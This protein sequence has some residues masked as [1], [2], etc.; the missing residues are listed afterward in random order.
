[1]SKE[2]EKILK[3]AIET[4]IEMDIKEVKCPE[5]GSDC[6]VSINYAGSSDLWC[7]KDFYNILI[8]CEKCHREYHAKIKTIVVN[9]YMDIHDR[10]IEDIKERLEE[11]E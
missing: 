9:Q 1:M 5:C 10:T 11:E 8:S 3:K 2:I 4:E 6:E 7:L